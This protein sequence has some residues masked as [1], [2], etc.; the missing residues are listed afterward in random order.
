MTKSDSF[1]SLL[2]PSNLRSYSLLFGLGIIVIFGAKSVQAVVPVGGNPTANASIQGSEFCARSDLRKYA[3]ELEQAQSHPAYA[4]NPKP[5][6]I[7]NRVTR[8]NDLLAQETDPAFHQAK[9]DEVKSNPAYSRT[10]QPQWLKDR[11]AEY[12]AKLAAVDC[13][14]SVVQPQPNPPGN[15]D[16]GTDPPSVPKTS[17]PKKGNAVPL[18]VDTDFGGDVDD[19]GAIAVFNELH[20]RGEAE[21]LAVMS[22]SYMHHAVAGLSAINSFYGNGNVPIGRHSGGSK[23]NNNSYAKYI[24]DRYPNKVDYNSVPTSTELYRKILADRGDASVVIVTIGQLRNIAALLKSKPDG[25]SSLD[26]RSL[27]NKKVKRF[28]V[29]GGQYPKS[30]GGGEANFRQSGS[31]VAKFVVENVSVPIV[32]NGF[33]IGNRGAGFSTGRTLNSLPLSNPVAG[34][35]HYFFKVDP[36]RYFNN[37]Q[38]SKSIQDWSIWDQIAIL[39]AVRQDPSYFGKVTSGYNSVSSNGTNQWRNAPDRNHTYLVKKMNPNTL[40]DTIVEPL[41]MK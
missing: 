11:L 7:V 31:G 9:I 5:Q 4:R 6:W 24:A 3:D 35:Y 15:P 30:S 12:E 17:G 36:P 22:V 33:E 38:P 8:Y 27:F 21:M 2:E 29:M 25:H 20:N 13:A 41:M 28:H 32:F 26:G 39:Y 40:A 37:G 10:P 14:T 1:N 23:N 19:V 16:D 18:I 34:G